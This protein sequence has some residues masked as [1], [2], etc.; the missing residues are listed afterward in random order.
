MRQDRDGF[1]KENGSAIQP[2]I[3]KM[4]GSAGPSSA[5]LQGLPL[6][7]HPGKGGQQRGVDIQNGLS[8]GIDK[9]GPEHAHVAGKAD[10]IDG[11]SLY[12]GQDRLF[13]G[14]PV[15]AAA[16]NAEGLDSRLGRQGQGAASGHVRYHQHHSIGREVLLGIDERAEIA[17]PSAGEDRYALHTNETPSPSI[18]SPM[19]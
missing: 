17:S 8:E 9:S 15:D 16:R 13:M 18:S 10:Q 4:H 12:R 2:G 7:I 3:N 6:G 1:L 14:G 5:G 11:A 19:R